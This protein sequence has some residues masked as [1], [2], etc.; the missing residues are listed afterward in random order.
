VGDFSGV[1]AAHRRRVGYEAA[2]EVLRRHPGRWEIGFQ[3]ENVGASEFWR[4]LATDVAGETWR[5][6]LRPVPGKPHI[7]HDHFIVLE[8]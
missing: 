4:R 6:D 1:R 7:T 3:A 8:V 2:R 5:E